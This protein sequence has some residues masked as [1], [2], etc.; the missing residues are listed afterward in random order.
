MIIARICG[1]LGNQLFKYAVARNLAEIHKTELKID[2]SSYETYDS[3]KYSLWAFNIKENIAHKE[4]I[5]ESNHFKEKHFHFDPNVLNL[6]NGT[7]LYGYWQCEKYFVDIKAIIQLECSVKAPQTDKDKLL[8][9]QM[10]L[11][12]SVG[13][14]IRRKDYLPNTY[15]DQVQDCCSLDYYYQC[16][17]SLSQVVHD[18]HFFIFSDDIQWARD[19]LQLTYPTT[20]VDHN[21][22]DKNYEDLRL[23][24]LCKHNII[25]N[26]SFSWWGAWLNVNPDKKVFAPKKWFNN[27]ARANSKDIIPSAWTK[28]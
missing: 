15:A 14:H 28:I 24:S 20:Y 4:E 5:L 16:I 10:A 9:E 1:G 13:L 12:E 26:S 17:A 23:M 6:S 3:H 25:A 7:Y 22:A 8:S 18:P 11:C 2:L 27:N 19:N 21:D